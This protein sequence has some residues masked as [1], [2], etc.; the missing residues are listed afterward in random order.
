M[1]R[2]HVLLLL[3]VVA[4]AIAMTPASSLNAEGGEDKPDR[5]PE[6]TGAIQGNVGCAVLDKHTPVKGKL[7]LVGVIYA[8]T[9][10]DV[11]DSFNCKLPKQ[12]FT[13]PGDV[14]ELNQYAAQNKI[15]LVVIPSNYNDEELQQA[16]DICRQGVAAVEKSTPASH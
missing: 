10:Y 14:K 6:V 13:G 5:R 7:L 11:I 16:K 4:A 12:K 15:K 1:R 8:R 2:A 9:Q 3:M